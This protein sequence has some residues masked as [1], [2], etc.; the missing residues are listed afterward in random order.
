MI[1]IETA[2]HEIVIVVTVIGAEIEIRHHG[3]TRIEIE[4]MMGHKG[5]KSTPGEEGLGPI[6][7]HLVNMEVDTVARIKKIAGLA[8]QGDLARLIMIIATR[9][10]RSAIAE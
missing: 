5:N 2:I 4:I 6:R 8:L 10:I 1:E 9:E 7:V 3:D